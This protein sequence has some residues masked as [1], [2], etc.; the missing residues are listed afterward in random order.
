[1]PGAFDFSEAVVRCKV[2]IVEAIRPEQGDAG[3][4][5]RFLLV[6]YFDRIQCWVELLGDKKTRA[7]IT[8]ADVSMHW[9][10]EGD[11]AQQTLVMRCLKN[12]EL[13]WTLLHEIE[14]SPVIAE[15]TSSESQYVDHLEG[16]GQAALRHFA[17]FAVDQS[18]HVLSTAEPIIDWVSEDQSA[19][20]DERVATLTDLHAGVY[21]T[22]MSTPLAS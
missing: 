18:A 13:E 17:I 21:T 6:R 2:P 20:F 8:F 19:W 9:E 12:K 11:I 22:N 4:A 16:V 3:F 1:M 14:Q 15:L 5:I 7:I 10:N